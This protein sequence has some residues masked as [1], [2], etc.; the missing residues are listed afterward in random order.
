MLSRSQERKQFK[1]N[2]EVT[3][4]RIFVNDL[5]FGFLEQTKLIIHT[6][7]C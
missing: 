2:K 5:R 3:P 6:L 1:I 4:I 7:N